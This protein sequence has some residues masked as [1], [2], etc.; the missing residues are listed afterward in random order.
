MAPGGTS[1]LQVK[2]GQRPVPPSGI[3]AIC[4]CRLDSRSASPAKVGPQARGGGS[5]EASSV[6]RGDGI[7]W[8]GVRTG[9]P[10]D[11]EFFASVGK[12]DTRGIP[13]LIYGCQGEMTS[14]CGSGKGSW[15]AR[16]TWR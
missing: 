5:G 1:G 11:A 9:V 16:C 7:G 8:Q 3:S 10:S 6:E 2:A 4:F 14:L 12:G 13:F 15:D